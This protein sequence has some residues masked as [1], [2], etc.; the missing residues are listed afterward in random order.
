MHYFSL[1]GVI[2]RPSAAL[3]NPIASSVPRVERP[4]MHLM[5]IHGVHRRRSFQIGTNRFRD[6]FAL[7]DA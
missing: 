5:G 6:V 1:I 4:R 7:S 3:R 2:A